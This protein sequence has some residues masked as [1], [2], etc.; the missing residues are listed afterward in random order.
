MTGSV[1]ATGPGSLV[2]ACVVL[3]KSTSVVLLRTESGTRRKRAG[4]RGRK[5]PGCDSLCLFRNETENGTQL[6]HAGQLAFH[7]KDTKASFLPGI[8]LV[9]VLV[10]PEICPYPFSFQSYSGS[11]LGLWSEI[12]WVVTLRP[13]STLHWLAACGIWNS[14]FGITEPQRGR[15][16]SGLRLPCV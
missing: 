4:G 1:T 7:P 16:L 5:T 12:D 13:G 6:S 11:C 8:G 2:R 9:S 10:L 15:T 3:S 14:S